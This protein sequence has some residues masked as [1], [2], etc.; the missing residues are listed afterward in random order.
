MRRHPVHL[1][2]LCLTLGVVPVIAA[3]DSPPANV[4]V[5]PGPPPFASETPADYPRD[6]SLAD[7]QKWFRALQLEEI[8]KE[9]EARGDSGGTIGIPIGPSVTYL[10]EVEWLYLIDRIE[11]DIPSL[12]AVT[13]KAALY[14]ASA[15]H[16]TA[17]DTPSL[18]AALGTKVFPAAVTRMKTLRQEEVRLLPPVVHILAPYAD[19]TVSL[20]A[21]IEATQSDNV[22]IRRAG[23]M[24]LQAIAMEEKFPLALSDAQRSMM[25]DALFARAEDPDRVIRYLSIAAIGHVRPPAD[26]YLGK[27]TALLKSPDEKVQSAAARALQSYGTGAN[28]QRTTLIEMLKSPNMKDRMK[29]CTALRGMGPD[30]KDALPE[31]IKNLEC[32]DPIVAEYAL[33]TVTTVGPAA[34]SALPKL[35]ELASKPGEFAES[36][37]KSAARI[38]KAIAK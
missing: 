34:A 19:P 35:D 11:S 26:P 12:D 21:L 29:A 8:R 27:L 22:D 15:L 9:R 5:R 14:M 16:D 25:A 33:I 13:A 36:C 6:A 18:R 4:A 32:A 17:I 1:A 37:R 7:I 3:P 10:P 24:G 23:V 30:A 28:S 2:C 38:R 31:L 20:P